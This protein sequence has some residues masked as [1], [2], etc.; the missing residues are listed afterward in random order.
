MFVLDA[1]ASYMSYKFTVMLTSRNLCFTFL[2]NA[3][4]NF[5]DPNSVIML[6]MFANFLLVFVYF[7]AYDAAFW[8]VPRAI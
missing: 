7:C 8:E 1:P 6:V 2:W 4:H 5:S 3:I